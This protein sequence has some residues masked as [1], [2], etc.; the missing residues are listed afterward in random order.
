MISRGKK[1]PGQGQEKGQGKGQEKGKG[2]GQG[3][4]QEEGQGQ[5]QGQGE[6]ESDEGGGGY[7]AG[8]SEFGE[9]GIDS[10]AANVVESILGSR[11]MA[12]ADDTN[13][14]VKS[15]RLAASSIPFGETHKNAKMS[16]NIVGTS[17]DK[18][19]QWQ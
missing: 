3:Q 4:G 15:L 1:G 10:D 18:N 17:S 2:Q 19:I 7:G 6:E 12:P 16:I 8:N 13:D 14:I 9:D 5:T 11:E